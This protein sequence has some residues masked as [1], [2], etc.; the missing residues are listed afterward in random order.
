MGK[1]GPRKG[2]KNLQTLKEE[3]IKSVARMPQ[4]R[5]LMREC[6]NAAARHWQLEA[7]D[8]KQGYELWLKEVKKVSH[9]I[10]VFVKKDSN[11]DL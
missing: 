6:D 4:F 7:S 5:Q 1:R 2:W 11:V 3:K 10:D 8:R 9:F